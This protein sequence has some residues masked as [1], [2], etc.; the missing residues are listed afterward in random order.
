MGTMTTMQK[1]QFITA[2]VVAG[3]A[4]LSLILNAVALRA[5]ALWAT[6]TAFDIMFIGITACFS[7]FFL[8]GWLTNK[9][10]LFILAWVVA[11]LALL[12]LILNM[13]ATVNGPYTA[14]TFFWHLGFGAFCTLLLL[15]FSGK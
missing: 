13:A 14:G 12:A 1:I 7:L 10:I 5:S 4:F 9:T 15:H 6:G 8:S 3:A 2:W 11:G